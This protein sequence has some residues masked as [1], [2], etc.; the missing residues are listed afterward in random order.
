M[1]HLTYLLFSLF[2]VSA[3]SPK[4]VIIQAQPGL[5]VNENASLTLHCVAQSHPAVISFTWTKMIDRKS[6][7]IHSIHRNQTMRMN[8][9]GPSDSG[10]YLCSARNEMGTGNSQQVE[11]KVKCE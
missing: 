2:L 3:D 9:V 5:T 8:S 10:W 7:I 11:V 1:C 4:N 6:E